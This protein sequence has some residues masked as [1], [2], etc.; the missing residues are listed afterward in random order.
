MYT[1]LYE[2]LVKIKDVYENIGMLGDQIFECLQQKKIENVQSLHVKQLQ[3]I[4][5][6]K[7][8][9]LYFQETVE[10]YCKEKGA[11]SIRVRSLFSYFSEEEISKIE[12]L[13]K[14]VAFIEENIKTML[15]KNQYYLNVLLKITE[16]IVDSVSEFNIE[17]NQNSQIFM[18]ELL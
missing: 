5:Q 18:N 9:S 2:Q 7:Q 14:T 15:L 10:N 11:S 4:E 1:N 8:L 12:E 16:G 3:Y 6:A 13:Q 17:K